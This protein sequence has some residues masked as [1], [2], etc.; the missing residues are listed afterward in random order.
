MD[1]QT[2]LKIKQHQLVHSGPAN[3]YDLA[4]QLCKSYNYICR[5]SSLTEDVPFPSELEVP[6]M[7]IQK[8]YD[9]LQLK[10]WECGFALV[11]LPGR[12]AMD[13]SEDH[14]L[15]ADYQKTAS[16]AVNALLN[17]LDNLTTETYK[18]FECTF[19]MIVER[20]LSV[21]KTIDKKATQQLDLF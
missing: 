20:S 13:K 6:A 17:V 8:N 11:K 1:F 12:I 5:I 14:K 4:D 15:S 2:R 18:T 10:A 19:Q 9:L 21:K 3:V 16:E 7:K